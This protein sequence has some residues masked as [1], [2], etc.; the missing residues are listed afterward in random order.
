MA[1]GQ[2]ADAE[3]DVEDMTQLPV[4]TEESILT[5]LEVRPLHPPGDPR[6]PARTI[7]SAHA[8]GD[9]ACPP[10]RRRRATP[11]APSIPP[12]ARSSSR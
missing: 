6:T 1:A 4:L 8:D 2:V 9:L 7:S 5:H 10:A 3:S 11:A 12:W